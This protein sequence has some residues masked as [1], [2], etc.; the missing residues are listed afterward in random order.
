M[1]SHV[2]ERLSQAISIDELI[3]VARGQIECNACSSLLNSKCLIRHEVVSGQ[4]LAV[5]LCQNCK[6]AVDLELPVIHKA[7]VY[8]DQSTISAIY[9]NE[10]ASHNCLLSLRN[11]V[12]NAWLDQRCHFVISEIHASETAHIAD[13]AKRD[14]VWTFAG[15]LCSGRVAPDVFDVL[16]MQLS[17]ILHDPI[18]PHFS[19]LH[20]GL[21]RSFWNLRKTARLA[22]GSHLN[23]ETTVGNRDIVNSQFEIILQEQ[24]GNVTFEGDPTVD[25]CINHV[26]QLKFEAFQRA[27]T[28]ERQRIDF[29]AFF[30]SHFDLNS[31]TIPALG[32][33][34]RN[35]YS[36]VLHKALA[37]T[38]SVDCLER[39]QA[40]SID[41]F[42]ERCD[43][44]RIEA[45]FEGELLSQYIRGDRMNER[46]FNRE[47]GLSR[48]RDMEHVAAF[49]PY[50]DALVVDKDTF[51]F[52]KRNAVA[53]ELSRY[54]VKLF[55]ANQLRELTAWLEARQ[56][57]VRPNEV[58]TLS[59]MLNEY[60]PKRSTD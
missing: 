40:L 56:S 42:F 13:V 53:D 9:S 30:K 12:W 2:A 18:T 55:A 43:V 15:M 29:L 10:A 50:V 7:L 21:N 33:T 52:C 8:L 23:F 14:A 46:R 24:M 19:R 57:D 45:I 5:L 59:Q 35:E 1:T 20:N 51:N 28:Y 47:Y 32:E 58:S 54:S 6:K 49:A 11:A 34:L 26:K 16:V 60:E 31:E 22:S 36:P 44:L 17:A 3:C 4:Q 37:D 25:R 39:L 41:D 38:R 48:V 27:V